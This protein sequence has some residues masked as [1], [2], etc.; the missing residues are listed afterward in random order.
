MY[1]RPSWNQS[2]SFYQLLGLWLLTGVVSCKRFIHMNEVMRKLSGHA[3]GRLD[4]PGSALQQAESSASPFYPSHSL[5][6]GLL[7]LFILMSM[8][9]D[10]T[11]QL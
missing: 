1:L 7:A 4:D 11:S 10:D 6:P 8:K 2:V 3:K 5:C 9:D